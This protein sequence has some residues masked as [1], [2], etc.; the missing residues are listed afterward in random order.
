M[1]ELHIFVVVVVDDDDVVVGGGVVDG[2]VVVI[3]F[4]VLIIVVTVDI[5]FI[6]LGTAVY[7]NDCYWFCLLVML[8]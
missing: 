5:S 8:L 4:I 2:V 6:V 7:N 1:Q 3:V